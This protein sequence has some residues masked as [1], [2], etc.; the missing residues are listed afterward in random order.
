MDSGRTPRPAKIGQHH[1]GA[2]YAGGVPGHRGGP[3]RPPNEF[4][5]QMAALA[6][7]G[8]QV[9]AAR[10]VLDN[11]DHPH[12][13][14]AWKFVTEQAYGRPSQPIAGDPAQPLTVRIVRE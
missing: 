1:G 11:P 12:W 10:G 3:G 14:S 5:R 2:L 9:A 6:D 8:A 7:R 4:K 13:L